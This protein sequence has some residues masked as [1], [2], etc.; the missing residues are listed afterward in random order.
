M[1]A[2]RGDRLLNRRFGVPPWSRPTGAMFR[3]LRVET[4]HAVASGHARLAARAG[5]EIDL[6][7]ELLARLQ[8][9]EEQSFRIALP[10]PKLARR[11]QT[12]EPFDGGGALLLIEVMLDQG[13]PNGGR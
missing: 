8:A 1:V 2:R 4:V 13:Q 3:L 6:E 11:V 10:P 7:R 9:V 12:R 5:I